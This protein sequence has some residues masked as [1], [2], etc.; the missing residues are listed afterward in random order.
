ML[1]LRI[2]S[3]I[4]LRKVRHPACASVVPT[5]VTTDVHSAILRVRKRAQSQADVADMSAGALQAGVGARKKAK[6]GDEPVYKQPLPKGAVKP[7]L[8][9]AHQLCGKDRVR[10]CRNLTWIQVEAHELEQL[11]C[12]Q[13]CL[14]AQA[15]LVLCHVCRLT[16]RAGKAAAG[17]ELQQVGWWSSKGSRRRPP[18]RRISSTVLERSWIPDCSA[19]AG[20]LRH[21]EWRHGSC[22]HSERRFPRRDSAAVPDPFRAD[23][24]AAKAG[25]R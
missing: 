13:R 16:S 21:A 7:C 6:R 9:L 3:A 19:A 10:A 18:S 8:G 12:R 23:R 20:A 14:Y 11:T 24:P 17:W 4:D 2:R 25:E 1:E 15:S 5:C 22:G